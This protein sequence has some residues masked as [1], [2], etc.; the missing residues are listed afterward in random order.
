MN[1]R[2]FYSPDTILHEYQYLKH[3]TYISTR[4][5]TANAFCHQNCQ[6]A[7]K[8]YCAEIHRTVFWWNWPKSALCRPFWPKCPPPQATNHRNLC[9]WWQRHLAILRHGSG[10]GRVV[11]LYSNSN[12]ANLVWVR[13]CWRR[14]WWRSKRTVT[15]IKRK[16]TVYFWQAKSQLCRLNI[17]KRCDI[18]CLYEL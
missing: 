4:R 13:F 2:Q 12:W 9:H 8:P 3:S 18:G 14:N 17:Q 1:F 5:F 10:W 11:L 16:M 15:W 7:T 6:F